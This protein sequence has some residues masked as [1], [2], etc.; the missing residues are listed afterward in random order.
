MKSEDYSILI[1]G[2][3]N[4]GSI[5]S[6]MLV[7][8]SLNDKKIKNIY[9]FDDDL[10]HEPN[11]P[12]LFL[13]KYQEDFIRKPKV[14]ALSFIIKNISK[15]V[16]IFPYFLKYPE[17]EIDIES[18]TIKIDCRDTENNSEKF[19]IKLCQ[20][21]KYGRLI[22]NPKKINQKIKTGNYNFEIDK[23][24]SFIFVSDVCKLIFK[25]EF[26]NGKYTEYLFDYREG[27]KI[28]TIT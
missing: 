22:F 16:K 11:L 23:Y 10:L 26:K 3:G 13:N 27:G 20:D 2:C 18:N 7:L 19:N 15:N 17:N 25:G 4:L 12:Y 14:Y 8:K 1:S 6:Y 21:G 24:Q 5:L 9:L 28:Y